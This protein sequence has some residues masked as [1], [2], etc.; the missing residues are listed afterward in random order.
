MSPVRKLPDI[1]VK[2]RSHKDP[3]FLDLD[4]STLDPTR[5]YRWVRC[6]SDEHMLSIVRTKLLGYTVETLREG[7]PQPRAQF[8]Q[9]P[10]GVIAIGDLILMSCPLDK[11]HQR[12]REQEGKTEALFAS[13]SAQTEEMAKEKGISVIKDPDHN[14]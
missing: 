11:F 1:Q 6:R 8:D 7:G 10:D 4:E 3:G 5:N 14:T 12:Q 9:R 13:V 2:D